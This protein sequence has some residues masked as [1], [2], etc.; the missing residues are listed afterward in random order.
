MRIRIRLRRR[1]ARL[2]LAACALALA[3]PASAATAASQDLRSPD[4]RDAAAQPRPV[5]QT[6]P[7]MVERSSDDGTET[8]AIALAG[9]ALGVALA[10]AALSVVALWR[11]PRPRWT[12]G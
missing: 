10:G 8:V 3:L 9:T 2:A 1:R 6:V 7:V 12:A 11:R 4:A 5:A